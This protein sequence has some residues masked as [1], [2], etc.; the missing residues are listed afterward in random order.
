WMLGERLHDGERG[1]F[2]TRVVERIMN[3]EVRA[4]NLKEKERRE[5][6]PPPG[7]AG[8][9]KVPSTLPPGLTCR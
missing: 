6:E 1:W 3:A 7:G 2:P 9:P 5:P 8:Q 4:Q